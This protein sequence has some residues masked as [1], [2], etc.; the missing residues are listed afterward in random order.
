MEPTTLGAWG[1]IVMLGLIAV[2]VPIAFCMA[3]IG[4]FGIILA[5]GWPAG[6]EFDFQRGFDA[7]WAYIAFE[8]F[9]FIANFPIIAV[10]L[11][12]MMGYVAFHAGFTKDIY[13][14]ARVWLSQL[15]GGLAMA[16]V[17][18]CAMFAAV[19][20]SSLA[21]AAAMGKLAVPEMLRYK[22]HPGIATGVVA[23][24]GTLGSLIPPS[25]LMVLYGIFTAESIGQLLMAGLIPGVLS[26]AIYMG[27][28]WIRATIN[29]ELAPKAES[30]S[31]TDRF[32]ALKGVWSIL[33]L[34]LIVMGGIYSGIVTPTEAAAAGC[35][36]A[37]IL[38]FITRRL[39]KEASKD[40]A[41]ETAKQ[42]A[43]VFALVL[44]AKIFVGF[45]ALTR[46]A[47]DLTGW[48]TNLDVD[49]IWIL[50][51]LSL[52]FVVLGTFMDPLGMMLLTLP[53][54]TPVIQD[55][56]YDLVWFGVIMVKFLEIG[57]ITPPVGLNVYVLKGVV[58]DAVPLE[59]IFKGILWFLAMDI[60]TLVVLILYPEISLWLPQQII[61]S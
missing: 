42:V 55:L 44:G 29:P 58:G 33:V 40:A 22:Y 20:G 12:L 19:S 48:A 37:W 32:I 60:L 13:Y 5:V 43:N 2:R 24:S 21:T 26:A 52:V 17:A 36:G 38:G 35:A 56:G 61:G 45:V 23:A 1:L 54:V 28:V 47:G 3:F 15:N 34:F 51:S 49:P 25:I 50:L 27:M 31:W 6:G 46:V 7:A 11:F 30:V 16:S 41:I 4:F 39:T 9:S 10:P 57:L 8:P 18:G 14:T 59:T 53:V